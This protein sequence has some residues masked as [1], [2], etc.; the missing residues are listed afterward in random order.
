MC[1][2]HVVRANSL[3]DWVHPNFLR[4]AIRGDER[5]PDRIEEIAITEHLYRTTAEGMRAHQDR[6]YEDVKVF[7]KQYDKVKQS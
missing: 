7:L 1:I 4:D 3:V 2:P 6:D 5:D